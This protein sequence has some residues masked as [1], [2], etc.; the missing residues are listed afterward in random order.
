MLI[1]FNGQH[2]AFG[3]FNDHLTVQPWSGNS[4]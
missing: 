2:L 3:N 4:K 1:V